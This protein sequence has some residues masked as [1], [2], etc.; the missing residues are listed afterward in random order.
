MNK[1]IRD[2]FDRENI[3]TKKITIKKNVR[4]IESNSL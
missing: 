3:I 4:I 2:L 1:E